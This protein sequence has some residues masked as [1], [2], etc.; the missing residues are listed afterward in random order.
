MSGYYG[1]EQMARIQHWFGVA[2]PI[3]GQKVPSPEKALEAGKR[4]ALGEFGAT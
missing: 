1:P 3:F 2:H 4:F